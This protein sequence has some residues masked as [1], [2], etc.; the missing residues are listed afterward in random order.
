ML[1][2]VVV[3]ALL[4][5]AADGYDASPARR[6][7]T[8]RGSPR[9][10]SRRRSIGPRAEAALAEGRYAEALVEAFRALASR[11]LRRGTGRGRP[12][13]TAHELAADLA[14]RL[15]R[16][17]RTRSAAG[18]AVRPRVLRGPAAAAGD[19]RA[20]LD[21]DDDAADARRPVSATGP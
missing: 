8:A 1:L 20:V 7:P 5:V 13:C 15:P 19:A 12:G 18:R 11:S 4:V 3:L 6:A 9:A 10:T 2:L 14:S 17:R 21:L 16:S